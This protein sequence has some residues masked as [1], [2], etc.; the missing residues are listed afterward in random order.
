MASESLNEWLLLASDPPRVFVCVVYRRDPRR[1]QMCNSTEHGAI[2]S[3]MNTL[4]RH[5]HT[6]T[7]T[8]MRGC[9]V[10]VSKPHPACFSSADPQTNLALPLRP[11]S[12]FWASNAQQTE[13]RTTHRV[14]LYYIYIMWSYLTSEYSFLISKK[15]RSLSVTHDYH[16][17]HLPPLHK[18]PHCLIVGLVTP[19]RS[20]WMHK[21]PKVCLK[22]QP[23]PGKN[24]F[25]ADFSA[26]AQHLLVLT[27]QNTH[28]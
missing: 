9:S 19:L 13:G 1:A 25:W 3:N 10:E 23:C 2:H 27:N 20:L 28:G 17:V 6:H 7:H 14:T 15:V 22:C 5:T 26:V 12:N 24:T 21:R 11:V 16:L 4:G 18:D 8:Q